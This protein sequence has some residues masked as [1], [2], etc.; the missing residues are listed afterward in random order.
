MMVK[1]QNELPI[2]MSAEF[3]IFDHITTR[4]LDM[5]ISLLGS[6]NWSFEDVKIKC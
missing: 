5:M 3:D 6:G 4:Q 1:H 2:I